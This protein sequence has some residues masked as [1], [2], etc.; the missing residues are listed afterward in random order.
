MT[1]DDN[2]TVEQLIILQFI[3]SVLLTGFIS[4]DISDLRTPNIYYPA[5]LDV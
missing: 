5:R 4:L 2:L 3:P 1:I